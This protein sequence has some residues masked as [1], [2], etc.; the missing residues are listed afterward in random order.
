LRSAPCACGHILWLDY[1]PELLRQLG[2]HVVKLVSGDGLTHRGKYGPYTAAGEH[3]IDAGARSYPLNELTEPEGLGGFP[4]WQRL[5]K[6]IIKPFGKLVGEIVRLAP[7]DPV[8]Q[9]P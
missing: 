1:L 6:I 7:A 5:A 3:A 9:G 8:R 2:H 4:G